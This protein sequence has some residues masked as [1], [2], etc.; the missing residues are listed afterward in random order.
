MA[1]EIKIFKL[2]HKDLGHKFSFIAKDEVDAWDKAMNYILYH[3]HSK[4]E[5]K[6]EETTDPKWIHNEYVS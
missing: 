3:S 1:T 6:V 4:S 2:I 5:Y